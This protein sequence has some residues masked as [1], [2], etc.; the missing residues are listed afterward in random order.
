[1]NLLTRIKI[2]LGIICPEH[3]AKP[4]YDYDYDRWRCPVTNQPV[5]TESIL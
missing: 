3:H 4:Y 5:K 1:M 2:K